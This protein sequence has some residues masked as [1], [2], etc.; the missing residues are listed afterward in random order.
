MEPTRHRARLM[1]DRF[2]KEADGPVPDAGRGESPRRH[3]L[4]LRERPSARCP[5][6]A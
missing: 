2:A 3:R 4:D 1:R 6:R 5:Q